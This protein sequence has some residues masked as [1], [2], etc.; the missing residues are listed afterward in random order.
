DLENIGWTYERYAKYQLYQGDSTY[1]NWSF[2]SLEEAQKEAKKWTNSHIIDL[3]TNNWVW[4]R[5]TEKDISSQRA[6][7]AIYEI[8]LDGKQID[9]TKTYSFLKDAIIAANKIDNS[10]IYNVSKKKIVHSNKQ[11][12][13]VYTQDQLLGSYFSLSSAVAAAKK[14]YAAEVRK[15]D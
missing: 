6:G 8:Q 3:N 9:N 14:L 4:D 2:Y 13:D 12:Y 11:Q 15:D 10:E 5:L 7:T 1:P